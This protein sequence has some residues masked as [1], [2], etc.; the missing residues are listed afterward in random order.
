MLR[1]RRGIALLNSLG[2]VIFL[3]SALLASLRGILE[4]MGVRR[5]ALDYI[6]LQREGPPLFRYVL[7]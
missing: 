7:T 1:G 2:E 3:P 5:V 4:Y 6:S